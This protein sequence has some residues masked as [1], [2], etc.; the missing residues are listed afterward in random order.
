VRALTAVDT[1]VAVVAALFWAATA[2]KVIE[3]RRHPAPAQRSLTL[4]VASLAVAATFLVPAVHLL[5]GRA[6]G[7]ANIAEPLARTAVLVAACSGQALLLRLTSTV[8]QARVAVAR[9]ITGAAAVMVVLWILFV[10]APVEE[11]TVRFTSRF[12]TEPLVAAYLVLAPIP[13]S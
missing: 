12:G 8:G 5:A 2:Y 10:A 4:T 11:P 7:V 6:T 13:F 3:L 1:M 9:R